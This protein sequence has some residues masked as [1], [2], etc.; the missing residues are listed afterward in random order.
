MSVVRVTV[1]SVSFQSGPQALA[2]PTTPKATATIE[3]DFMLMR[4][5]RVL[6]VEGLSMPM[7]M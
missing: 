2:M 3:K 7:W 1:V 6:Q 4:L 5:T